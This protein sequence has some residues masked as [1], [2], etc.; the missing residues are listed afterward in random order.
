MK[1]TPSYDGNKKHISY[2]PTSP[3]SRSSS[4]PQIKPWLACSHGPNIMVTDM[5][6]AGKPI[7]VATIQD[8]M[9]PPSSLFSRGNQ[10]NHVFNFPTRHDHKLFCNHRSQD[11]CSRV[12]GGEIVIGGY[13]KI[14]V[15]INSSD[16]TDLIP[17][18]PFRT[19]KS[20]KGLLYCC[21]GSRVLPLRIET[22]SICHQK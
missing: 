22:V 7:K 3:A 11:S 2:S 1:T 5:H 14:Y 16:I 12:S 20:F 18:A 4:V 9:S 21:T 13:S 8:C 6:E 10:L 19:G 17:Q 15:Q